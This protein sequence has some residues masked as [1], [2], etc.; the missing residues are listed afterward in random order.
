M[1]VIGYSLNDSIVVSDRFVKTS[2]RSVAVRLTK[3][4]TC[5]DPDAAPYLDHIRYY[6]DG[7]PVLYLFGGPVLE[8]FSLTM[9][10][11]FPSVLHL[12]SMWHLRWL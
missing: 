10:I 12:P 7:Y 8:G 2:A 4:L 6:L 5:P 3:S 11:G 9:L 1:S